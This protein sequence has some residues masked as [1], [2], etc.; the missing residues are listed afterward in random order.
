MSVA[1]AERAK[2]LSNRS[3]ERR[4]FSGERPASA[5]ANASTS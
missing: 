4:I 3:W 1:R 2:K 5:E